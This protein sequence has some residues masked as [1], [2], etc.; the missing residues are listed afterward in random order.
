M[1]PLMTR[2]RRC[3]RCTSCD[4]SQKYTLCVTQCA[5]KRALPNHTFRYLGAMQKILHR[6]QNCRRQRQHASRWRIHGKHVST[7]THGSCRTKKEAH[8]LLNMQMQHSIKNDKS[9]LTCRGWRS[10]N[11]QRGGLLCCYMQQMRAWACRLWW[12]RRRCCHWCR[13][14]GAG[15]ESRRRIGST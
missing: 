3:A 8:P 4:N 10:G 1:K 5:R 6:W 14:W 7:A 11:Q 9:S 13:Y 15:S 2:T 12:A